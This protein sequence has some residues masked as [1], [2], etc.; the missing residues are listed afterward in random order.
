MSS[1]SDIIKQQMEAVV[2]R[3]VGSSEVPEKDAGEDDEFQDFPY[4][5]DPKPFVTHR[6]MEQK[7]AEQTPEELAATPGPAGRPPAEP[8]P[9]TPAAGAAG[10]DV[11]GGAGG[12]MGDMAGMGGDMAGIPGM[13]EEEKLTSTEIGRVYELKKIYSR[14]TSVEAYLTEATDQS[15]IDLRKYVSHAINLFEVVISNVDQFKEKIDPII[16]TYYEFVDQVYE[17]LRKF[18]QTQANEDKRS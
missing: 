5:D 10:A 1:Y 2:T 16:V 9:K 7:I 15:L 12:G 11:M 8:K 3:G 4:I 6:A 17:T 14:L 18:Y 13:E